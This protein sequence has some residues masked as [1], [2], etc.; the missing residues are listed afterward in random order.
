MERT[1]GFTLNLCGMNSSDL[2]E[3]TM[4]Y[5]VDAIRY[6][7]KF[8][9]SIEADTIRKQ[10]IRSSCSVAANYRAAG[11]ARSRREYVA[12][13]SIVVEESD[14]SLFWFELI[15]ETDLDSG[16]TLNH[17]LQESKELLYIFSASRKTA[18]ENLKRIPNPP[19]IT[20]SQITKSPNR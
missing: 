1:F 16:E 9:V 18:N 2:R 13:L 20:N 3:R 4:K 11:R 17:L 7:S 19:E 12:K 14:E 6:L 15:K 5:C 8:P 10:L